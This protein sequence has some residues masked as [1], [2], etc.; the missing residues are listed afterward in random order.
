[1]FE[2]LANLGSGLSG[3]GGFAGA[4]GGL[5]GGK[6]TSLKKVRSQLEMQTE[7]QRLLNQTAIQ[8]RVSDANKAGIHPLY[9]IGGNVQPGGVSMPSMSE[10]TSLGDRLADMGQNI[11]RAVGAREDRQQRE[12][13]TKSSLLDIER[14]QIEN[15]ILKGQAV[16][17]KM[18]LLNQAGQP[19]SSQ[20][21]YDAIDRKNP[22]GY[23]GSYGLHS[24]VV[25]GNGRPMRVINPEIG[26]AMGELGQAAYFMRYTVPDYLHNAQTNL[27][28]RLKR[29][30]KKHNTMD[31]WKF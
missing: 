3:I 25:D 21:V 28:N 23:Q 4:I 8:D 18:A 10:G 26:D 24:T 6:G 27:R 16:S 30:M 11:E 5:F 2:S 17:S 1:M 22:L 29:N 7:Y 19:P 12:L 15:D 9:A 20:S 14:K 13:L 31:K